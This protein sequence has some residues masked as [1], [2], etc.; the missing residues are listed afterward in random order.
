MLAAVLA[1]T[2]VVAS[3]AASTVRSQ[4]PPPGWPALDTAAAFFRAELRAKLAGDWVAA[5][6]TLYPSHQRVA[7]LARFVGCERERPFSAP[8]Q[9]LRVVGVS[10][11][12]V[13]V[14]G[15]ARPVPGVT[16]DVH[17]ELRWY[18]PRDPI[19]LRHSFHLV[20]VA[21]RWT[22][23]LSAERYRLYRDG[24]CAERPSA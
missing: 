17:V 23:L 4:P 21:G 22:W 11:S 3:A 5:W 24:A 12:L 10:E 19:V 7:P 9:S 15:V 16:V 1:T 2:V 14:P 8:L 20:P 18:G 13:R 6:R